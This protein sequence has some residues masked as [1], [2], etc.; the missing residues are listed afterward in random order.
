MTDV[1][2]KIKTGSAALVCI[3]EPWSSTNA[4]EGEGLTYGL[5]KR[6]SEI[7]QIAEIPRARGIFAIHYPQMRQHTLGIEG[8]V[9]SHFEYREEDGKVITNH[10]KLPGPNPQPGYAFA[11]ARAEGLHP[12]VLAHAMS[13]YREKHHEK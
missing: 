2:E 5:V 10:Q 4:K 7:R 3:D 8:V 1:I 12:Q 13:L 9:H 11:I 6:I